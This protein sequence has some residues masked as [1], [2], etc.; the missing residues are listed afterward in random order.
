MGKHIL[1]RDHQK[2]TVVAKALFWN[3]TKFPDTW[4]KRM[5]AQHIIRRVSDDSIK[6][7]ML[8]PYPPFPSSLLF[9]RKRYPDLPTF[10]FEETV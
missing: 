5:V 2:F 1:K 6:K 8:K 10:E 4:S 7:F 3:L 9:S